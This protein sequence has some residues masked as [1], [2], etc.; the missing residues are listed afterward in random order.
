MVGTVLLPFRRVISSNLKRC[1]GLL[2]EPLSGFDTALIC[3][4]GHVITDGLK[5]YPELRTKFCRKCGEATISQ[6]PKCGTDIRGRYNVPGLLDYLSPAPAH[7]H[8]CGAAYPWTTSRLEALTQIAKE[9]KGLNEKEREELKASIDELVKGGTKTELAALRF[10]KL[11]KKTSDETWETM[12]SI[13]TQVLAE[14]AKKALG[15]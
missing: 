15:L 7:C 1:S 10:K 9:A 13:L 6:C 8:E 11:I 2:Y 5:M 4:N 12:K 14:A 3:K